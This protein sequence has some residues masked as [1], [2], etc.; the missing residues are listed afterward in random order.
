MFYA[1]RR[2]NKTNRTRIYRRPML[3]EK[4]LIKWAKSNDAKKLLDEKMNKNNKMQ[5]ENV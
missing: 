1:I 4:A 5:R 2:N 3:N